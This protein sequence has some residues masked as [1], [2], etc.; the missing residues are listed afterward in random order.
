M[1][2]KLHWKLTGTNFF[3]PQSVHAKFSLEGHIEGEFKQVVVFVWT[4]MLGM[5]LTIDNLMKRGMF[6]GNQCSM[7]KR[8][9]EDL[10]HL[11]HHFFL[12]LGSYWR[13]CLICLEFCEKPKSVHMYFKVGG[14]NQVPTNTAWNFLH[15]VCFGLC[16][17]KGIKDY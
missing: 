9:S 14:G 3:F 10:D 1:D 8:H 4:T 13:S 7:C 2:D 17:G 15:R 12:M 5:T 16:G 6:M 11:L